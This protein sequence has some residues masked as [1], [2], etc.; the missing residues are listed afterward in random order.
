MERQYLPLIRELTKYSRNINVCYELTKGLGISNASKAD[1]SIP[2]YIC[3]QRP[4]TYSLDDNAGRN[5]G[6]ILS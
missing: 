2:F 4:L 6:I 5:A 1:K 3:C